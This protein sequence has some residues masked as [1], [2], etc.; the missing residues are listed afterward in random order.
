M[1]TFNLFAGVF[2]YNATV[3]LWLSVK[4]FKQLNINLN[5]IKSQLSDLNSVNSTFW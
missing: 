4:H 1:Q 5:F 2:F 3:H